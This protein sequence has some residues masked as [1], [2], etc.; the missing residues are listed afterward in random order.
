MATK[1]ARGGWHGRVA[2]R[3][4]KDGPCEAAERSVPNGSIEIHR[5]LRQA[6]NLHHAHGADGLNPR[7]FGNLH[8]WGYI[9]VDFEAI[10]RACPFGI[11]QGLLTGQALCEAGCPP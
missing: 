8:D 10:D 2:A 4:P 5:A 7:R 6:F 3:P 1:P 9:L 11:A